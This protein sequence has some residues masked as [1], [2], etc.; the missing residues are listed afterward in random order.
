[1]P[2]KPQLRAE[3]IEIVGVS[4]L[5]MGTSRKVL[6]I[7]ADRLAQPKGSRKRYKNTALP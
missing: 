1:M 2:T 4:H 7:V 5:G 6:E 3:N